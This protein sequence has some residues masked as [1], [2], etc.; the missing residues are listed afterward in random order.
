MNAYG[1]LYFF[2]IYEKKSLPSN[3]IL[4]FCSETGLKLTSVIGFVFNFKDFEHTPRTTSHVT[5]T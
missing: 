4:W 2:E 5:T 3:A 1:H